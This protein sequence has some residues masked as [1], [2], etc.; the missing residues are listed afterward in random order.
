MSDLFGAMSI[1]AHG[2]KAQGERIRMISEN[3]ANADT[4]PTKPG[5]SAYQ[6]KTIT[7]K[8]VLDRENDTRLV[9]V[10]KIQQ[11][12]DAVMPMKYNPSHPAANKAGYVEMPNVNT[13]IE[14]MDM[15]ESHRTYEANMGMMQQSRSM[16]NQTIELLRTQ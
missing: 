16:L 6:R 4:A 10:D 11:K 5:E 15:K 3:V 7:F 14:L 13:L 1:S 9:E 12:T 2:M 8:N